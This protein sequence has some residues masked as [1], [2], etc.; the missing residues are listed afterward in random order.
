MRKKTSYTLPKL[1]EKRRQLLM[2]LI[3]F[4]IIAFAMTFEVVAE[5]VNK[6]FQ[7]V[8]INT[9]V[10]AITSTAGNLLAIGTGAL[11]IYVA[12]SFASVPVLGVG[13]L[14]VGAI[15]LASGAWNLYRRYSKGKN[16]S[17]V[18]MS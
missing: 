3:V 14:A 11:L 18:K 15:A 13:L 7:M 6:G 4:I 16:S 10:Q 8:G 17:D 9:T 1:Q 12:A 5:V 2:V